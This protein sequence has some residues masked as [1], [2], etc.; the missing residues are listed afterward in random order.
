MLKRNKGTKAKKKKSFFKKTLLAIF[1]FFFWTGLAGFSVFLYLIWDIPSIDDLYSTYRQPTIIIKDVHNKTISNYGD[2]FSEIV[3]LKDLPVY[4]PQTVLAV[5]DKRFYHHFGID[6]LGIIRAFIRN[7][8]AGRVVQGGSSITQQLAKNILITNGKFHFSDQSYKR[9]AQELFL[10]VQLER[11]LTKN[12]I[13]TL[14]LNRVYLGSGTYGIDAASRLYFN[15]PASHLTIFESAVIGGLLKA[16]S[17][18]SPFSNKKLAFERA[19]VV[20]KRMEE[21]GYINSA[22]KYIDMGKKQFEEIKVPD[23]NLRYFTDWIYES[24]NMYIDRSVKEDLEVV[25]TLDLDMQKTAQLACKKIMH[26]DGN[27]LGVKEVA[28]V[29]MTPEGAVRAMV[30]GINHYTSKFNRVTQAQRQAGSVI[31]PFVHLAALEYLGYSLTDYIDD[32]PYKK[33]GWEPS[34]FHWHARGAV[35][36]LDGLVNSVNAV[37]IRLAEAVGINR[38]HKF[39]QKLGIYTKQPDNLTIAL[40]AGEVTLLDLTAAFAVLANKGCSTNPHGILLIRNRQGQVLYRR[41]KSSGV[42]VISDY[43]LENM[44]FALNEVT[45]RGT[46]RRARI[47][48]TVSA[49]TGS[50]KNTDAW[51]AGYREFYENDDN[52]GFTDLVV[53]VWAGNDHNEDMHR[54]SVG[55]RVPAMIAR[56]FF[57]RDT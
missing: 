42:K 26:S 22:R 49:K 34:N 11:K 52:R 57:L 5:E 20:L 4:V 47:G 6:F 51:F 19:E 25:T 36:L 9:K 24:I 8:K 16:P 50:N 41:R 53:G 44:R 54:R 39:F 32:T 38:L 3:T 48:N 30:G 13:L 46:G 18:Y 12:Q 14:Y 17:K 1:I 7:K 37:T 31:K 28:F 55:G 45:I 2:Y 23:Q 35:T 29:A 15:K 27:D 40:G 10:A 43:A 33:G 21:C 56:A